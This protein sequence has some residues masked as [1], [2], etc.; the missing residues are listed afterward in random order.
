VTQ[1]DVKRAVKI[2]TTLALVEFLLIFYI[3]IKNNKK[4]FNKYALLE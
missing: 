4:Y 3:I 2:A 1:S